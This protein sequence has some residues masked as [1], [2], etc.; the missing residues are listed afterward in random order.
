MNR[1]NNVIDTV[2]N[3]FAVMAGIGVVFIMLA[4]GAEVFMRYFLNRPLIWVVEV[5]GLALLYVTFLVGA[6]VLKRERHVRI[7]IM[8]NRLS[9]AT[10]AI[11][12]TATSIVCALIF[13]VVTGYGTLVTWEH[14]QAGYYTPTTMEIPYAYALV[15]IPVGSLLLFIQFLRR[16]SGFYTSW[17]QSS[18][19]TENKS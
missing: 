5:T 15:I 13:L 14:F 16:A 3:V 12:N 1:A 2:I 10:Q 6:W 4:I 19:T 7:D 17:K 11:L 9:P 18:H 8:L